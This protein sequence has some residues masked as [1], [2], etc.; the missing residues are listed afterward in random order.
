MKMAAFADDDGEGAEKQ[1]DGATEDVENQ[2]R[3][4]HARP[5]LSVP[6]ETVYAR[7]DGKVSRFCESPKVE[8]ARLSSYYY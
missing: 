4:S 5:S 2:E 6:V 1:A 8:S 7:S 3:E